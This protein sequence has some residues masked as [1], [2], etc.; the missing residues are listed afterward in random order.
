M[1][2]ADEVSS[3]KFIYL[4]EGRVYVNKQSLGIENEFQDSGDTCTISRLEA[5]KIKCF[6]RGKKVGVQSAFYHSRLFYRSILYSMTY[7]LM[8]DFFKKMPLMADL[9]LSI[10]QKI[11]LNEPIQRM[12]REKIKYILYIVGKVISLAVNSCLYF[13]PGLL[14]ST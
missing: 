13:H 12:N 14:V 9:A 2:N 6:W 4:G 5:L 8:E 11:H 3:Q 10:F 7:G 1:Q